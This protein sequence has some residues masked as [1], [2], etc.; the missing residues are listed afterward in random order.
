MRKYVV[1][2]ELLR[3][4]AWETLSQMTLRKCSK[5]V[6]EETGYTGVFL[7]TKQENKMHG[8]T[9]KYHLSSQKKQALKLMIVVLLYIWEDARV[10]AH[11]NYS[12][13]MHVSYLFSISI[14]FSILNSPQGTLSEAAM[15]MTWW[16]ATFIAYWDSRQDFFVH[17][18]ILEW[19]D[20]EF[21]TTKMNIVRQDWVTSLS[22]FGEGNGN[23][24]QYPCLENLMDRTAW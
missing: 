16:W 10:W 13:D 19:L 8:Q 5:E 15:L 6:V 21:K 4:I 23:Q 9:S 7:K 22:L 14:L 20:Q 18:G 11:W 17:R 3:T 2:E 12:F 1:F 24:L